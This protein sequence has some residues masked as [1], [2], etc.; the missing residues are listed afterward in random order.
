MI[1]FFDFF[2]YEWT[3]HFFFPLFLHGSSFTSLRKTREIWVGE[4]RVGGGGG[5]EGVSGDFRPP[6]AAPILG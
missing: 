1:F 4:G 3:G 5:V 2:F 6:A